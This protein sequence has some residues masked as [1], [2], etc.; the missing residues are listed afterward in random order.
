MSSIV[1]GLGYTEEK[2]DNFPAP[3][4]LK[5]LGEETDI[6]NKCT[7]SDKDKYFNFNTT[8]Q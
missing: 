8:R 5:V 2:A 6:H 4:N 1:L 7:I 3:R